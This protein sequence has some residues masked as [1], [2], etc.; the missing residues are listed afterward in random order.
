MASVYFMGLVF[1]FPC[2][3]DDWQWKFVFLFPIIPS[4][5][6]PVACLLLIKMDTPRFYLIYKNNEDLVISLSQN[7]IN[8]TYIGNKKFGINLQRRLYW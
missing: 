2:N 8:V 1:T 3:I 6:V 5:I 7:F 4:V